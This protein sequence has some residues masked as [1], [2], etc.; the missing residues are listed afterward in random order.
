MKDK[1]QFVGKYLLAVVSKNVGLK[2][3]SVVFAI[4]LW[5]YVISS[6]TSITRVK[7]HTGLQGY[8]TGQT[9]L[10]VYDLAMVSDP[11]G[12]LN[13]ITVEIE[14]PKASYASSTSENVQVMLDVSSVRTAGTQEVPIKATT[15]YGKVTRIYPSSLTMTFEPLDSRIIPINVQLSGEEEGY[16]YNCTRVNPSQVTV[17]GATSIVQSITS[18]VVRADMT[19]NYSSYSTSSTIELMDAAGNVV[20]SSLVSRSASS[21]SL[22][23]SIYPE[24]ELEVSTIIDDVL[25]GQ[26]ADGYVIEAITISP[27]TVTVAAEQELLDSLDKLI[28]EPIVIDNPSQSFTRRV[29]IAGLSDIK[30]ISSEQVYVS[31]QISEETVSDWIENVDVAC[32]GLG[33]NL[34]VSDSLS[35]VAVHVTGPRSD[36][37]SLVDDRIMLY[38][39]LSGLGAGVHTLP[40]NVDTDQYDEVIFEVEP[41]NITVT[42]TETGE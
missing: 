20:P 5:S 28:I 34:T 37:E 23:L 2:I 24:K 1:L 16:W 26:A 29:S 31:V 36:I 18:A 19:G 6:N 22:V 32:F 27:R 11:T 15:S 3:L 4:M 8:V 33:D 10:E 42:V 25:I 41:A 39:D 40:V 12:A 21:S 38:V 14:V 35:S 17:S 9:T 13:N 30:Y 7:T